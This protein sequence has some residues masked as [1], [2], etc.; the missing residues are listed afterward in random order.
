M[1]LPLAADPAAF[2]STVVAPAG[3]LGHL[4]AIPVRVALEELEEPVLPGAQ[5]VAAPT[6]ARQE[7]KAPL[8]APGLQ[9]VTAAPDRS[10][11]CD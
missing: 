9:A 4:A 3:A 1:L 10:S 5:H 6:P 11:F 8:D 7:V 2:L